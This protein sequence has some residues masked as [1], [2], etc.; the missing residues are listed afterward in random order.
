[1]EN[2]RIAVEKTRE[3]HDFSLAASLTQGGSAPEGRPI[4]AQDEV[5]GQPRDMEQSPVG[6]TRVA[7]ARMAI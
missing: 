6:T 3:G 5:L 4:I 7:S 1:V 2:S